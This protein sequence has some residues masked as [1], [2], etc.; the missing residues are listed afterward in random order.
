MPKEALVL[1]S[2]TFEAWKLVSMVEGSCESCGVGP[3]SNAGQRNKKPFEPRTSTHWGCAVSEGEL[4]T[5]SELGARSIYEW[6][7]FI[8]LSR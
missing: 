1:G 2:L 6:K 3:Y 7:R 5:P 8:S 4:L